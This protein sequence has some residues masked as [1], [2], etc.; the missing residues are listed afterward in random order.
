MQSH[1][2]QLSFVQF[3]NLDVLLFLI[4]VVAI[5]IT[6]LMLALCKAFRK[7]DKNKHQRKS[8]GE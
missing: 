5:P 2:K 8:K 1:A 3:H 4:A 6:V 7:E